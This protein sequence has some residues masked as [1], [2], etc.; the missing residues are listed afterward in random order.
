[1]YHIITKKDSHMAKNN[2]LKTRLNIK[3]KDALIFVKDCNIKL[4]SDE[5]KRLKE[6]QRSIDS[7]GHDLISG[8]VPF[9]NNLFVKIN[10]FED[11]LPCETY[12]EEIIE[13]P[14]SYIPSDFSFGSMRKKPK[15]GATTLEES[16]IIKLW[17]AIQE[18]DDDNYGSILLKT[19]SS[20]VKDYLMQKMEALNAAYKERRKFLDAIN[21]IILQHFNGQRSE[22]NI[23][24][25]M[26]MLMRGKELVI[27]VYK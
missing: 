13:N 14:D 8:E 26:D 4:S 21:P 1:M 12:L 9:I 22:V 15:S 6:I 7:A 23:E 20:Q 2:T 16:I 24:D 3:E 25:A 27:S 19:K 11:E 17:N 18:Y 5:I 10:F